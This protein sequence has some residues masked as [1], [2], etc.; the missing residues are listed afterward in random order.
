MMKS[1]VCMKVFFIKS[2]DI[3]LYIRDP[4][5]YNIWPCL[6]DA[7]HHNTPTHKPNTHTPQKKDEGKKNKEIRKK[8]NPSLKQHKEIYLFN[9]PLQFFASSPWGAVSFTAK[10]KN[11]GRSEENS[12]F[13]LF[14]MEHITNPYLGR[15]CVEAF[16]Q[17]ETPISYLQGDTCLVQLI[18]PQGYFMI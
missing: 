4:T 3:W 7:K 10:Q 15:V 6:F 13:E 2:K 1:L 17:N 16:L 8:K 11:L 5:H 12:F 9:F 14:F 18:P